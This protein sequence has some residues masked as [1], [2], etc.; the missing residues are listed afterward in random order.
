MKKDLAIIGGLFL[1]VVVLLVFGQ[2][3]S[4]ASFV[5][6]KPAGQVS[7]QNKGQT[8]VAIGS[9]NVNVKVVISASER[10]KGLSGD[11]SLP[12]NSG[13]LFVFDKSAKWGI[14]MKNM[15]FPID[16]I[17]ID[18]SPAGEK[19]IVDIAANALPESGKKDAELTV[20]RPQT[21]SK[22]I[23]EINAGLANLNNLK[24][25]DAVNF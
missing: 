6:L 9:L 25:G 24:V 2:G 5:G 20:Y 15:K 23:L 12:I 3:F 16:I 14:W 19:R 13:M 22:Y 4:S 10:K 11:D 8:S 18:D 7:S 17:W 21:D 1:V